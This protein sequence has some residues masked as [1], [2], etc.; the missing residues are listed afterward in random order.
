MEKLIE[1]VQEITESRINEE[2]GRFR[3]SR[4]CVEQIFSLRMTVEKMVTKG[5]KFM[6]LSLTL[7]KRVTELIGR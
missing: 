6:Q 1:R 2:Q 4:G 5:K 3:K 7:R